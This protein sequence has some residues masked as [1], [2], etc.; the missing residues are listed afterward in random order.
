[1]QT[2]TH[3]QDTEQWERAERQ[4]W[5]W[6]TDPF[7]PSGNPTLFYLC[8]DWLAVK[9]HSQ[10]PLFL[11]HSQLFCSN[12]SQN[13][14]GGFKCQPVR[15]KPW[16]QQEEIKHRWAN[17]GLTV[18]T[19]MGNFRQELRGSASQTQGRC[20]DAQPGEHPPPS[21]PHS[22]LGLVLGHLLFWP[23][24]TDGVSHSLTISHA[25]LSFRGKGTWV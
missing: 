21:R 3:G 10:K 5:V 15:V 12:G 16:K 14:R 23:L 13:S 24:L 20:W 11:G 19:G 1:M 6:L 2:N 18:S 7:M 4:E 8:S 22:S 9:W 25:H 17:T